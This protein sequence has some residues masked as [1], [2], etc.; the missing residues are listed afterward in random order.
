[1]EYCQV[2]DGGTYAATTIATP[3]AVSNGYYAEIGMTYQMRVFPNRELKTSEGRHTVQCKAGYFLNNY[4]CTAAA[5]GTFAPI[6]WSS[7][8]HRSAG[9]TCP[10]GTWSI[11]GMVEC[12]ICPPGYKCNPNNVRPS[13]ICVNSFQIGGNKDCSSYVAGYEYSGQVLEASNVYYKWQSTFSPC[14][15]WT[16]ADSNT[17][18][19]CL[20]CPDGHE[21]Y[22]G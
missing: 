11:A 13:V 17:N 18:G 3:T 22:D 9:L 8:G 21:C 7:S 6:A 14:P 15:I 4:V 10:D 19:D 16:Y 2:A 20:P 5:A 1:M 12:R